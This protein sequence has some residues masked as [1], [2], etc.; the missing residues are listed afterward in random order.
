MSLT[1]TDRIEKKIVLR[2]PRARVWRA[3]ADAEQFGAWFGA[4]LKGASFR[5]GSRVRGRITAPGY[6]H[7]SLEVVVER[8]EPERRLSWRWHPYAVDPK[9]DYSSEPTTLVE[10]ELQD[11][12][13]GTLLTVVESGFDRIPAARRA[14]AWRMNDQG[15]SAQMQNIERHVARSA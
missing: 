1:S 4:D 3:L 15:W 6:E 10:F 8:M 5:P 11:A 9:V 7:L 14:E 12:P 13:E 2:A